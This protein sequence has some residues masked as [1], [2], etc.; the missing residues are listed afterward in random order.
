MTLV[1]RSLACGAAAAALVILVHLLA[2]MPPQAVVLAFWTGL[3][4]ASVMAVLQAVVEIPRL[5]LFRA[6][7][8]RFQRALAQGLPPLADQW[9]G[10]PA[11][12]ASW[13]WDASGLVP[14]ARN[15]HGGGPRTQSA[16]AR[17][18]EQDAIRRALAAA[19]PL[20]PQAIAA[21]GGPLVLKTSWE[22]GKTYLGQH[23]P[24]TLQIGVGPETLPWRD[25][26]WGG[27][28]NL[29]VSTDSRSP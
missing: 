2:L 10:R 18:A 22:P 17:L 3:A 15:E 28:W 29:V 7:P 19:E 20:L 6:S 5:P 8:E 9:R 16:H 1:L 14:L 4:A 24:D 11:F 25:R 13:R 12:D 23:R 27:A 21:A 26:Q